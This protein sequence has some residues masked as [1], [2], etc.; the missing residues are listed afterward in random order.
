MVQE[1]IAGEDSDIYFN[2]LFVDRDGALRTSFVGRKILCWPPEIGGTAS[3]VAAPERHKELTVLSLEFLKAIGF[4][5]LIG[6]EYKLERKSGRFFMIEPTVYRTDHQHEIAPLNGCNLLL[7]V[8]NA[9]RSDAQS[10]APVHASY[11]NRYQWV[12]E[13]AARYSASDDIMGRAAYGDARRIDAW[14]RWT[15]P[16]PGLMHHGGYAVAKL[17][18][19]L[20]SRTRRANGRGQV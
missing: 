14:F 7:Q 2:F 11:Q 20:S 8:Y 13:P 1:W 19:V 12:D 10:A 4:R 16:L 5:G 18:S 3:C 6:I 17:R 9:C 15:D